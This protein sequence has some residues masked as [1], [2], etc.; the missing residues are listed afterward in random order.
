MSDPIVGKNITLCVTGSIAC[1]KSIDIASKL[2]QAG[3]QVE[4]VMTE[5]ATKFLNPITFSGITHKSVVTSL[6]D[7]QSEL[8]MDHVALAKRSDIIIVA[9]ATANII[10]EAANGFSSNAVS[11][12]LLATNAP[13]M[14]APAMDA[15]MYDNNATQENVH[16]LKS[17]GITFIGPSSGRLASGLSGTGRMAETYEIID[18]ARIV[19]GQNGDLS[20][21]K[22]VVTAG[23]TQEPIDP[24]R[25]IT[26]RSSGKMGF[27]IAEAARDRGAD[28][29]LISGPSSLKRPTGVT[30]IPVTTANEMGDATVEACDDAD[31]LIMAAAVSDWRPSKPSEQKFKKG[32]TETWTLDM[33]RNSDI[34]AS[35]RNDL[36]KIAF[37]AE[38]EN[39]IENAHSKLVSKGV[40]MV[41]ANDVAT[42]PN[43]FGSDNNSV[44]IL[45][46]NGTVTE[47]G[48]TSKYN[49]G[50]SILDKIIPLL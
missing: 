47:L 2:V 45:E 32:T 17:R 39:V 38:T 25:V 26:N 10:A 28:V 6:F 43:V 8:S 23:G 35:I 44:T 4:V 36:I 37:A 33:S 49:I 13:V 5:N 22:L 16:K 30:F 7:P 11:A 40:D 19:L 1:Y 12:T 29:Y 18:Y 48:T 15:H 34:V 24:V 46:K 9:P 21:K 50:H 31:I 41:V 42:E 3:A 20:N 14:F 27:R